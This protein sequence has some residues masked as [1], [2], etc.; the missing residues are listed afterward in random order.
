MN[1]AFRGA[2]VH[3]HVLG[4]EYV[5][6]PEASDVLAVRAVSHPATLVPTVQVGAATY[7]VSKIT[8]TFFCQLLNSGPPPDYLRTITSVARDRTSWA[9]GQARLVIPAWIE[10]IAASAFSYC[11]DLVD[12]QFSPNS[13]VQHI[14]GFHECPI[15]RRATIPSSVEWLEAFSECRLLIDLEFEPNSRLIIIGGLQRCYSMTRIRLPQ[16]LEFVTGFPDCVGLEEVIWAPGTRVREILGFSYCLKLRKIRIPEA[17]EVIGPSAFIEC[18]A[19]LEIQFSPKGRLHLIQGFTDV[20]V[21]ELVMPKSLEV[22]G[23]AA[24]YASRSLSNLV[25]PRKARIEQIHGFLK[26]GL[27]QFVVPECVEV[28]CGF[29]RSPRLREVVFPESGQLREIRGFNGCRLIQRIEIPRT[30]VAV[31]GFNNCT[32]LCDVV[33]NPGCRL[34]VLAGFARCDL[35]S[36][37][38]PR[39]VVALS[40]RVLKTVFIVHENVEKF[41]RRSRRRMHLVHSMPEFDDDSQDTESVVYSDSDNSDE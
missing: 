30:V 13:I 18:F 8:D 41:L 27:V 39:E 7:R 6:I 16:S 12:L 17:V 11:A 38:I 25:F 4:I 36:I 28:L 5:V 24:F 21:E 23:R 19:L 32:K 10:S 20:P 29:S 37:A 40:G 35:I 9:C 33:I 22:V 14:D 2:P 1:T 3:V 26:C 15:L 31:D 34:S